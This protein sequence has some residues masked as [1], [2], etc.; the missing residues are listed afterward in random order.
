MVATVQRKLPV[1]L[2]GA[3]LPQVPEVAGDAKSYAERLFK[4]PVITSLNPEQ[5]KLALAGP[6]AQEGV[7]IDPDALALAIDI[8]QGYPYFLQELGYQA[9]E[10]AYGETITRAD[11]EDAREAYETKLDSSFF[12]VR[13]DRATPLQTSYLRAMAEFGPDPQTAR[14]VARAMG[15]ESPQLAPIRAE[16]VSTGLLYTPEH[17]YAA[18]TVPGF[19]EF[20]RRTIP[21]LEVPPIRARRRS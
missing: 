21:E 15:R 4:F 7:A 16:L 13:L 17:G 14:D 18:F 19:D 9:W 20:L 3:G 8:T 12:R 10:V 2:V 6:A 11:I 1:T 5:A